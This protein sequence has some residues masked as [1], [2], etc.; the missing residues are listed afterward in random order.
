MKMPSETPRT[1]SILMCGGCNL[2]YLNGSYI[3]PCF[4]KKKKK[5]GK[6]YYS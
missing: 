6:S 3:T 2:S 4:W 1:A 5:A